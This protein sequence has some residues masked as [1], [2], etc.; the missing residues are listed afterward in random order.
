MPEPPSPPAGNLL[1]NLPPVMTN[2]F[3]EAVATGQDVRIERIVSWGQTS[4]PGFW[5]DQEDDEF[6]LVLSGAARLEI[7]NGRRV[8]L[9]P[10]DYAV[11]PAHCRH[12]VDW[13]DPAQPTI[14]L[15][16]FYQRDVS[17]K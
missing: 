15:A 9:G 16:V 2:E 13:T 6:V 5:Y 3:V 14:W 7:E 4:P 11:L 17:K 8:R 1:A 12:R 10:G